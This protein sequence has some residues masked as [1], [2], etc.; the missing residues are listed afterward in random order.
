MTRAPDREITARRLQKASAEKFY[1][2]EVD[3]DWDAPLVDGKLYKPEHRVSLYGTY[4]WDRLTPEQRIELGKQETIAGASFGIYAEIGLMQ[5]LLRSVQEGDPTTLHA[6]YA[7]T[8]VADEC[9][10]STMFARSIAKVGQQPYR[11]PRVAVRIGTILTAVL[12]LGPANF[13]GALF[14]EEPFDRLQ[15]ENMADPDIQPHIRMVNRIHVTEEA[16]H[17]TYARDEVMRGMPEL[18]RGKQALNRGLVALMAV[19][20]KYTLIEPRAYRRVGL[21]PRE[22]MKVAFA[23]PHYQE[24][25]RWACERLVAFLDQA[26]FLRGRITMALWRRSGLLPT[27]WQAAR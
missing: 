11:L 6:Q 12:P 7:L 21:E 24:T 13:A 22:A 19:G 9:R 1:D 27:D 16:R 10:H 5:G 8:E 20:L 15:R 18:G 26:G 2:P 3:L 25:L 14:V 4:L 23:N 17:M